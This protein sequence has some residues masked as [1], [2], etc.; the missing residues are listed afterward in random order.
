MVF[1]LIKP[2]TKVVTAFALTM[3]CAA[4]LYG[5]V[6]RPESK[7]TSGWSLYLKTEG[8]PWTRKF[9]VQLN[10]TGTLVV[11][12]TDPQGSPKQTTSKLTVNL[13]PKDTQDIYEQALK[14]FREFRF[15]EED[16]RRADGTS[17]TLRLSRNGGMLAMQVLHIGQTEEE[18]AEL[19][20]VLSLINRHLTGDNKIY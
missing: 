6:N 20:K 3:L 7:P 9:E 16:A 15:A 5:Q 19:A 10:Q 11:T 18:S 17:L 13:A 2:I 12:K 14:A 8:A 1:L 4:V